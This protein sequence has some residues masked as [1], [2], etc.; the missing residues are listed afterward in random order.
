[1]KT[2]LKN[3]RGSATP[4]VTAAAA[5]LAATGLLL[6]SCAGDADSQTEAAPSPA[7]GASESET[8]STVTVTETAA[9]EPED[10]DVDF[11]SLQQV[12]QS[13]FREHSVQ[14]FT[15]V[16]DGTTGE[17]FVNGEF[18]TCIGTP[19]DDIPDV[20]MP[21]F[22]GPPGAVAIGSAGVA[23]VIV[24]GVPP[25]KAEL[26]TGQWV[27]FGLVK[28]AKPDDSRLACVSD[29]AAIQVEGSDRD[30]TTEGP[31]LDPEELQASVANGPATEY[32]TGTDV[33][34][35]APML[36]GAMEGHRLADVVEGE[37]TCK[38]AM[39]VLDEYDSRKFSEGGGNTLFVDFDGWMCSSPTAGRSAELGAS[40]VCEHGDRGI[41]VEAPM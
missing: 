40:T 21:P 15:Y 6:A 14:S 25:A 29:A 24:E 32:Q 8:R 3:P 9:Q 35:Q 7:A 1:M 18:V 41:R 37:I 33:L 16:V 27:N 2:M 22:F 30:I 13:T 28:C 34:V 19:A 5:L 20:D 12:D 23:Y 36:C 39:E 17:C 26:E 11:A 31:V 10:S 4:K 38:E